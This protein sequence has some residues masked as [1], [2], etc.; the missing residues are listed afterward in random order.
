[1]SRRLVRTAHVTAALVALGVVGLAPRDARAFCRSRTVSIDPSFNPSDSGRCNEEGLPL[2]WRNACV[3][4]SIDNRV[5][6]KLAFED[7]A[8]VVARSFTRWTGASCTTEGAATSR[9][10]IDVRDV[11]PALCQKVETAL[12]RPNVNVILFR[13]NEWKTADGAARSPETIGLTTVKFN[14][15]TGEIFGADME[16]NTFHHNMT[17]GEPGG[18]DYD[19]TSVV[20]HEAGHFLGMAHSEQTQAVMFATYDKGRSSARE[21][22]ADDVRGICSVYRPDG[23][24]PVLGGKVTSGGACDPTPYAG[25]QRDC[26]SEADTGGCGVVATSPSAPSPGVPL[27]AT[28]AC[29]G[30]ALVMRHRRRQP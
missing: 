18:N 15:E 3:G 6:R 4:Y 14:T 20:T 5:S 19:L 10:S 2:F 9:T 1:M 26:E 8:N 7:V 21:L 22:H 28:F 16:L 27:F 13:D 29:L 24:R 30:A 17:A 12:D 23:T 25:L 11:G